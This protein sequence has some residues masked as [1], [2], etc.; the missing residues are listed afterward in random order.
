MSLMLM[1]VKCL[2]RLFLSELG[3]KALHTVISTL[4]ITHYLTDSRSLHIMLDLLFLSFEDFLSIFDLF[5]A[6]LSELL[7]KLPH[8]SNYHFLSDFWI[9]DTV[10]SW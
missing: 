9:D 10:N 1:S 5:L 6:T 8:F 2:S 3:L 4:K 7:D